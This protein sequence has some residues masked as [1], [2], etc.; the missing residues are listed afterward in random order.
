MTDLYGSGWQNNKRINTKDMRR[1]Y[2]AN[3]D[4]FIAQADQ[5]RGVRR[6]NE[7]LGGLNRDDINAPVFYTDRNT[8]APTPNIGYIEVKPSQS[9]IE[10]AVIGN[11]EKIEET[12]QKNELYVGGDGNGITLPEVVKTAPLT[13]SKRGDSYITRLDGN[14]YT[15]NPHGSYIVGT[16][17]SD[18]KRQMKLNEVP[19]I[20]INAFE[21]YRKPVNNVISKEPTL[22]Y[23]TNNGDGLY[24]H[25]SGNYQ[26]R[27]PIGGALS[28]GYI[29]DNG[30]MKKVN[31]RNIPNIDEILKLVQ[32]RRNGGVINKSRFMQQGGKT[33][34]PRYNFSNGPGAGPQ[35]NQGV[36]YVTSN[37]PGMSPIIAPDMDTTRG[38]GISPDISVIKYNQ[39]GGQVD[40][41]QAFLQFLVQVFQPQSENQL[42][43]IIQ[44]IGKEGLMQLQQAFQQG[45]DPSQVRSELGLDGGVQSARNG[46]KVCPEGMRLVFKKGGCLCQQK[47]G[48]APKRFGNKKPLQKKNVNPNDTI[49]VNGKPYDITGTGKTGYP[50]LTKEQYRS[51]PPSKQSDVDLKDQARG[52]NEGEG[53]RGGCKGM[54]MCNGGSAKKSRFC[55]GGKAKFANGGQMGGEYL[56]NPSNRS[57]VDSFVGR[58]STMKCGG[59]AKKRLAKKRK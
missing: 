3:K 1:Q 15:L 47:G 42:K 41:Q 50:K 6:P 20:V 2:E 9:V 52:R 30:N 43:Q 24:T 40:E 37:G 10:D 51:L 13:V 28:F 21:R 19:Q 45:A 18:R 38:P 22:A 8:L 12:P 46:G 29:N 4:L 7:L 49:H 32:S 11:L 27:I 34:I 56:T 26:I 25:N 23:W 53:T 48:E 36:G 58:P 54:K 57:V 35:M 16:I 44:N 33:D 59:K 5:K 39:Q 31:Y 55:G 14:E 17:G